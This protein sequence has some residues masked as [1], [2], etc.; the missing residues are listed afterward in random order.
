MNRKKNESSLNDWETLLLYE[1]LENL[2]TDFSMIHQKYLHHKR[3][4]VQ[5]K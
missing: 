2:G 3:V 5:K 1:G 4:G